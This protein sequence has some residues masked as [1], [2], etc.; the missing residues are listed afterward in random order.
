MLNRARGTYGA[1]STTVT[2]VIGWELH[3]SSARCRSGAC[4]GDRGS[5][6]PLSCP[7]QAEMSVPATPNT[8]LVSAPSPVD[9]QFP[10]LWHQEPHLQRDINQGGNGN[11]TLQC[12]AI[13]SRPRNGG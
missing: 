12:K 9:E 5:I 2:T 8:L 6:V 4:V 10:I 3:V 1:C 11:P 7:P 13:N